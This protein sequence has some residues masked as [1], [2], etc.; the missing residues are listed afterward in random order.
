LAE[1][2]QQAALE[3]AMQGE[4]N[5]QQSAST[6]ILRDIRA[7]FEAR[8]ASNHRDA[9][10]IG[11]TDLANRLAALPD[12]PS[13]TWNRGRPILE[14]TIANL[15]KQYRI[16]PNTIK[17]ADGKQPNGYMRKQFEDAFSRYLSA[18]SRDSSPASPTQG[19]LPDAGLTSTSPWMLVGK[20]N[21]WLKVAESLSLGKLG[22]QFWPTSRVRKLLRMTSAIGLMIGLAMLITIPPSISVLS[23]IT[24]SPWP[25]NSG[26]KNFSIRLLITTGG[27]YDRLHKAPS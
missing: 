12:R 11:S 13:G 7:I 8:A 3:L 27:M 24:S 6:L 20:L 10:W 22:N 19:N 4:E 16:S 25:T 18:S 17:L 15:L 9:D 5:A 2:S 21:N 23:P 26:R 1:Q 14:N